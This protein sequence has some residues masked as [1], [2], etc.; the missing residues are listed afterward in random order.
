MFPMVIDGWKGKANALS[1]Q[2]ITTLQSTDYLAVDYAALSGPQSANIFVAY[3]ES[4]SKGA[5][6]HSPRVCL[7][8][9]G[10]EIATLEQR[11]FSEIVAGEAG[12]FNR[13]VIQKGRT[14]LLVYYWYQQGGDRVASEFNMKFNLLWDRL[15]ASVRDGALVRLTVPIDGDGVTAEQR[16]DEVLKGFARS[17][18]PQLDPF[19]PARVAAAG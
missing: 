14:R 17:V 18:L 3:Y 1:E 2:V 8:G 12:D 10:W 13:V 11:P 5:A 7:P 4:L 16:A 15:S 6:I 9:D 19:L